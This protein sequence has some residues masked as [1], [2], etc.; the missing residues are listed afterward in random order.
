MLVAVKLKDFEAV[1]DV[2]L[3]WTCMSLLF[4]RFE[5]KILL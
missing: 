2:S 5:V 3:I 4:N 1:N